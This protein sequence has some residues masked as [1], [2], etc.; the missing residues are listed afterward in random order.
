MSSSLILWNKIQKHYT[1]NS[2]LHSAPLL[3]SCLALGYIVYTFIFQTFT[4]FAA[5]FVG[6]V[7]SYYWIHVK[8]NKQEKMD[9]THTLFQIQLLL[10][11][12][13]ECNQQ[14]QMHRNAPLN[15]AALWEPLLHFYDFSTLPTIPLEGL[16][17]LHKSKTTHLIEAIANVNTQ[18]MTLA[19][20]LSELSLYHH[21]YLEKLNIWESKIKTM[22]GFKHMQSTDIQI[23][24]ERV[25]ASLINQLHFLTDKI[26]NS[27]NAL[28]ENANQILL[29][30]KNYQKQGI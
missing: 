6:G 10:N 28:H 21:T 4:L 26:S 8:M 15:S 23:L 20:A 19:K 22:K 1:S 7:S 2:I 18:V 25:G 11:H 30:I 29:L 27:S 16:Y 14:F 24:I 9:F 12:I 3:I 5:M 13:I 17:R